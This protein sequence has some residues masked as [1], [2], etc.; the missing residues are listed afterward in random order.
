MKQVPA[1]T[2]FHEAISTL[3]GYP[4]AR[5]V[6]K[7]VSDKVR[8]TATHIHRP[9]KRS[10][11]VTIAVTF[12]ALNYAGRMFVAACKRAGEPFPVRRVQLKLWPKKRKPK[13]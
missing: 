1:M 3:I 9:D 8:V 11:H 12:G 4:P 5:S 2:H 7:Y 13:K 10:R 6:T